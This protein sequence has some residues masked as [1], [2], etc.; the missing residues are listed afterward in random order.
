MLRYY[1]DLPSEAV[2]RH[3]GVTTGA[4]HQLVHR[5]LVGLRTELGAEVVALPEPTLAE[6]R[7]AP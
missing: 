7:D 6:V 1:A 3:L 4:V 5:A 2:A